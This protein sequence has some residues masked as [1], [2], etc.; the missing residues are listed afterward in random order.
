METDEGGFRT[1]IEGLSD[2]VSGDVDEATAAAVL[3]NDIVQQAIHACFEPVIV[4]VC[5]AASG[6]VRG[7][8]DP[9]CRCAVDALEAHEGGMTW[10]GV[11]LAEHSDPQAFM[12]DPEVLE[13]VA[14]CE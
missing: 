14:A 12:G 1:A 3:A 10:V 2:E 4:D 7:D 9:F 5:A 8:A 13:T 6:E 11:K